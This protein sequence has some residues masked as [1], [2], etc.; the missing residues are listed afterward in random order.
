MFYVKYTLFHGYEKGI[1]SIGNEPIVIAYGDRYGVWI[2]D[3]LQ[4]MHILT[5][6]PLMYIFPAIFTYS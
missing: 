5:S 2:F 4:K 1:L 3:I 6:N